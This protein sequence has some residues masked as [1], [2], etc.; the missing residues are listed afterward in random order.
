VGGAHQGKA[1]VHQH[2]GWAD[3]GGRGEREMND[4]ENPSDKRAYKNCW[5]A[6]FSGVSSVDGVSLL[7]LVLSGGGGPLSEV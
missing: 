7:A 1:Q 4:E 3:H 6:F 5:Q 2:H